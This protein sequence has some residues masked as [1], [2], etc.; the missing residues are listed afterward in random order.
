MAKKSNKFRIIFLGGIGEIGKNMTVFEWN[1]ELIVIDAGVMFPEDDMPGVDLVIPDT[2]YLLENAS[3]IKAVVLTHGHEDHIG[4]VPFL[5]KQFNIP[6]YGTKLTLGLLRLKLMEQGLERTTALHEIK[7]GDRVAI[8]SFDVEFIHVNHSIPDVVAIAVRTPLGIVVHCSDFKFDQT[9][10][11]GKV[12][13]LFRLAQ[14]GN[15]G[16]LCLL[17]DST[18]AER[19]GYTESERTV[20][21][22]FARVFARA[23]GRIFVATFASNV[24]R[25]QQ[26]ISASQAQGRKIC[27]VGRSMVN[28][29]S[30]AQELGYLEIPDG[31]LVDVEQVDRLPA[32]KVV[33]ITTGSQGEP[34]SALTRIAMAEHGKLAIAPGDTVIISANP[35][36]GNEKSVG[37]I[38]NHLFK[39]GATVVYEPHFGIHTSGHAKQ[40]ELKLLLNL[41]KPRFFVPIH[42]EHRMLMKHAE[43]AEITG[44]PKE[45]ICIAELG[46]VLE[47]TAK[48]LKV[49]ERVNAGRVYVDGLGVGDVGNI[50]LRD[51][52]QLASDGILIVVV[53]ING[54]TG[55]LLAG[56]DIVTRG[57]VYVRESE[58]LI[59]E[60]R[61]KVRE[62]LDEYDDR[63][64]TEWGMLKQGVREGLSRYLYEQT[65]R[66]P[67]ILPIIMEV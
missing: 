33:I 16:V 38:I 8:G 6:V 30:I 14:F 40:E 32:N 60:A 34:M 45:N 47:F 37:K 29:V 64:V 17:S 1:N 53:T 24:H 20:G 59:E 27:V 65:K 28:V 49:A 10:I 57:F 43:L 23:E 63:G 11:D 13:D 62:V 42:G 48:G 46:S 21:E 66:R 35:I 31:M 22:T 25:L 56:P 67:M 18:N 41:T 61:E 51:R 55:E 19:P 9:P 5:L 36:P 12:T 52:R 54:R 7:A 15:E 4:G 50:V 26:I 39:E 44:V 3:R 2:T 58:Q